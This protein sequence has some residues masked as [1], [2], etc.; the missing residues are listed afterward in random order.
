[1]GKRKNLVEYDKEVLKELAHQICT[2]RSPIEGGVV[3]EV[4]INLEG[5]E[6]A[7]KSLPA[8]D[9]KAI[10]KFFGLL[11]GTTKHIYKKRNRDVA[12]INMMS[13]AIKGI[14]TLATIEYMSIYDEDA[15]AIV[16]KVIRKFN[17]TGIEEMSEMECLK[18]YLIFLIF[19]V[20][21]PRMV[22]ED[23][24][25]IDLRHE[26]NRNFD[27]YSLLKANWE[28]FLKNIPDSTI[29]LKLF[30]EMLQMFDWKD[31]IRM[32]RFARI[33]IKREDDKN[34]ETSQFKNF[35]DVRAFKEHL[36]PLGPWNMA[37]N[38]I[39]NGRGFVDDEELESLSEFLDLLREEWKDGR[40]FEIETTEIPMSKG[41]KTVSVYAWEEFAWT[42]IYEILSM[43]VCRKYFV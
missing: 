15:K 11:P 28:A 37:T 21:G 10:E 27:E 33:P 39:L 16:E 32:K 1:M 31:V 42:D 14:N 29:N 20:N 23:G 34:V 43:Y 38:F 3:P 25:K 30:I 8:D 18:F 12:Y 6:E 7:I 41:T 40:K 9:R 26:K 5:L 19:F 36:F 4:R 35:G 13:G 2:S 17:R 22:Y 24:N